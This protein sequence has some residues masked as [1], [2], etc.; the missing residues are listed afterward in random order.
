[1]F[2]FWVLVFLVAYHYFLYPLVV[3]FVAQMK[4][5]APPGGFAGTQVTDQQV[6]KV[7]FIIAAYNEEKVLAAKLENT[8]ALDYPRERLEIIVVSDGS[9]DD[10]AASAQRYAEQGVISLHQPERRGKTA[11]LNR[12]VAAASGDIIIFSDAN[13]DFDAAA[14]R[15][16]VEPFLRDG[17]VGGVCGVKRIYPEAD[18][19]S[20]AGDG[21]YWKY[22]S[23]IKTAESALG[24]ITAADGEIFAMRKALYRA[25]DESLI[26]DDAA[27]TFQLIRQG[28]RILYQPRAVSWESAS[29]TIRDDFQV[30]VR[31]V[32]GG[33]QTLAREW[34]SLFPPSD[35]FS[36][37]FL[38]HKVLR[39]VMPEALL[40]ILVLSLIY[41]GQGLMS[42]FLW[43]QLLFYGLAAAGWLRGGSGPAVLYF[44]YYFCAMNLA[45]LF[46]LVR[47]GKGHQ[48]TLW[49]KAK[50]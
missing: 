29:H 18:R 5:I 40:V 17:S 25:V 50:R 26:N 20:S 11:A 14:V 41:G 19:Q 21:L 24:S 23:A 22:E 3:V 43:V 30:K 4:Q 39:W 38:S 12:A 7:S 42:L 16:L 34:R 15:E 10:S 27:I 49:Q 9:T 32:A 2:L 6:P 8:L 46:G 44:P 35:Q 13:N 45:A 28:Y 48:T 31:M 36:F 47:Y 37:C 33:F 1:M